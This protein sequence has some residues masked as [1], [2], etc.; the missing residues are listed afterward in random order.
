M[1]IWIKKYCRP[2]LFLCLILI[3]AV[4][5]FSE[6]SILSQIN[7]P[8]GFRI[9]LYARVPGA[10]SL[11][12]SKQGTLFAG[13]RK[14]KVYALRD[15]DG[16]FFAE[17]RIVL[18]RGLR[19][20]NGVAFQNGHLYVAEIHRILRFSYIDNQLREDAN[21]R[22]IM[23]DYP[24]DKHHGW[25][26]IA[27]GPDSK[28]YVPV[29]APCNVCLR[30]DPIYSS[31]TR[32]NPDGSALEI[33]AKGIRNTVGFDWHPKTGQLWF[34]EN[35]RDWMGDNRPPDELNRISKEKQ[36]FGFPFVH[37]K[38]IKDPKY[39]NQKPSDIKTQAPEIELGPHVAALGMRFYNGNMFP[40]EYK[41]QIFIA[42]HGS[43]NRS[44]KIGYRISLVRLKN[45]QAISYESFATGWLQSGD[46][47]LGRPVD[48]LFMPDGSMLLSD[49]YSGL[50]YR[51]S[52]Q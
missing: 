38:E 1:S 24:R 15:L 48:L 19:Q 34:T 5:L 35:G 3:S 14:D 30:D 21:F 7:L 45:N 29:G 12:L 47:V 31:L 39:Y 18:A 6:E 46:R 28:L 27:F 8:K 50:V 36:H 25:K 16:D 2:W 26:F 51:I 33:I 20:P 42:E 44:E 49:D 4:T 43:W 40:S 22:V 10:R 37:G 32:I 23:D 11:A 17:E 9:K 13:T 52:Y 41:G